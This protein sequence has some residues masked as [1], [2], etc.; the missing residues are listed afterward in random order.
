MILSML[1]LFILTSHISSQTIHRDDLKNFQFAFK[2]LQYDNP[3]VLDYSKIVNSNSYNKIHDSI[4]YNHKDN[5]VWFIFYS[6]DSL[7][8]GIIQNFKT[9]NIINNK[10][11]NKVF[12]TA[13]EYTDNPNGR[14]ILLTWEKVTD[15]S[16]TFISA[17]DCIGAGGVSWVKYVSL[18]PDLSYL[19][20]IL[21]KGADAE[22]V[23]YSHS[24]VR[25]NNTLGDTFYRSEERRV[26]KE[27]RSRWAP[28][29]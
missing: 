12:Y 25:Y 17:S 19:V 5:L 28:Y 10:L 16:L 14:N 21:R 3:P 7:Q 15:D 4:L 13:G 29:H 9:S 27:C 26:G 8:D 24:F 23:W 6:S 22:K 20:Y 1:L 18:F 11:Y 2:I